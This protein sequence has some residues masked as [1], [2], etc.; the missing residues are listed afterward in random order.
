MNTLKD[1]KLAPA[2]KKLFN[3]Y[4][5][6]EEYGTLDLCYRLLELNFISLECYD[7]MKIAVKKYLK[8]NKD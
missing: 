4:D 1:I 7:E 6:K 8:S 3:K 5:F 2:D